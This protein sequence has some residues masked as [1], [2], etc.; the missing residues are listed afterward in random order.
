MSDSS[1][2]KDLE[3]V[4]QEL[5]SFV[6]FPD[7][8]QLFTVKSLR[9]VFYHTQRSYQNGQS[10]VSWSTIFDQLTRPDTHGNQCLSMHFS[11]QPR[12]RER[13]VMASA[14]SVSFECFCGTLSYILTSPAPVSSRRVKPWMCSVTRI[15][16]SSPSLLSAGSLDQPFIGHLKRFSTTST[17]PTFSSRAL[18]SFQVS[19]VLPHFT[20]ISLM[21][22]PQVL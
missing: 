1:Y 7:R 10:Y 19:K 13:E 11:S 16:L 8:I 20:E 14:R 9:M 18:L 2:T 3:V 12:K 6:C 22:W 4:P 21:V 5:G 15:R 17:K